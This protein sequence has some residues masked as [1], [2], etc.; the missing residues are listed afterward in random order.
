MGVIDSEIKI[1]K[2]WMEGTAEDGWT[3]FQEVEGIKIDE[4]VIPN[5]SVHVVRASGILKG[6]DL[7]SMLIAF[8]DGGLEERRKVNA[9]IVVHEKS[10]RSGGKTKNVCFVFSILNANGS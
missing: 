5:S 8:A 2:E 6:V 3:F 7:E 1:R 4:L 9:D 10:S